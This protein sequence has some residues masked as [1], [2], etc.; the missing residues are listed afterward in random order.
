[1]ERED[2]DLPLPLRLTICTQP[3]TMMVQL[4]RLSPP[5]QSCRWRVGETSV[6]L[7]G[8]SEHGKIMG[9]E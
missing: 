8:Q 4:L 7:R 1:M 9:M 6:K 5:K 3:F 2:V